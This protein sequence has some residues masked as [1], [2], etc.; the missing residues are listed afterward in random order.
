MALR[1][2]IGARADL[3]RLYE[4]QAPVNPVAATQISTTLVG[5]AKRIPERPR[6]GARLRAFEDREV[7]RIL[8]GAYEIRY[9]LTGQDVLILRIFHT[10]E[11]R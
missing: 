3:L 6:L 1:W 11:D 8:V 7:R 9:E 4:F 10:R 5:H 2:T